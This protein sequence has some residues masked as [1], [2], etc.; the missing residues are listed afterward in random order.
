MKILPLVALFLAVSAP[1]YAF[2]DKPPDI[3]APLSAED[4]QAP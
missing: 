2:H 3:Q 1:V 4:I